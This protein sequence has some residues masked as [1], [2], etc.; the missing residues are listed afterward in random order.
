MP[1]YEYKC[2][3]C[4]KEI[5]LE[6]KIDD[7]APNCSH[8]EDPAPAVYTP[9]KKQISKTAFTLKGKWFKEGY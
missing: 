2:E 3:A 9:M 6:Q 1:L 4:G 8:G 5:E 7:P